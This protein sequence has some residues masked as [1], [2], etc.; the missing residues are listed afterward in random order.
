M[1][2]LQAQLSLYKVSSFLSLCK[3]AALSE[4]SRRKDHSPNYSCTLGVFY[5]I[6]AAI[7]LFGFL[8]VTFVS[9]HVEGNRTPG[10]RYTNYN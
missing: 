5:I 9:K 4:N 2:R 10:A 8:A 6:L 7:A 3:K 1:E